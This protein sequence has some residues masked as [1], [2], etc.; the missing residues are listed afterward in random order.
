MERKVFKILKRL[1]KQGYWYKIYDHG[2]YVIIAWRKQ[3]EMAED[4]ASFE[5][6]KNGEM[7]GWIPEGL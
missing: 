5:V 7:K 4:F 6:Y 3:R 1:T 2:N